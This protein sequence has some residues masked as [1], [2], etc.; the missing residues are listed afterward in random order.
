MI[1]N[2]VGMLVCVAVIV[3][4][5]AAVA[6]PA[7]EQRDGVFI[8][9][10][11]GAD[12]PQRVLMALKMA[13]IMSEDHDVLIYFDIKG[14]EVVLKDAPEITS[15]SFLTSRKQLAVLKK[16]GVTMM[17]C[18]GCLEA[19]GKKP[20]DLSEGIEVANKEAFFNFTRGRI[21]SLDY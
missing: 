15:K 19:A 14:I 17:A 3:M 20:A 12:Q 18:P 7:A 5:L 13:V 6:V 1:S 16:R 11:S 8:H 4:V 9:L 2:R 21:L 10:S